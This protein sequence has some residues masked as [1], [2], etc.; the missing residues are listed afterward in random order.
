[1]LTKI[2]PAELKQKIISKDLPSG[3]LDDIKDWPL[4][5]LELIFNFKLSINKTIQVISLLKDISLRD[6]KPIDNPLKSPEWINIFNNTKIPIY[7]KGRWLRQ[8]LL[9]IRY[10]AYTIL[11]DKIKQNINKLNLPKNIKIIQDELLTL[12]KDVIS[13]K[14]ECKDIQDLKIAAKKLEEIS[15]LKEVEELLNLLKM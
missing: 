8:F 10:P 4:D 2:L 14:I 3:I 1:M 5:L 12:E 9:S 7:Q 11:K 6:D 13:F 15:K